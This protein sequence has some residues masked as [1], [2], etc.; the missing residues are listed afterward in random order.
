LWAADVPRAAPSGLVPRCRRC[1]TSGGTAT[2][3]EPM[4]RTTRAGSAAGSRSGR[5]T[6]S[7]PPR[8]AGRRRAGGRACPAA[9]RATYTP[10]RC[11]PT[12]S[13]TCCSTC[14]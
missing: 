1:A 4:V 12:R 9:S 5:C 2:R 11:P 13:P 7:R 10:G 3:P 8:F 6:A 14:W